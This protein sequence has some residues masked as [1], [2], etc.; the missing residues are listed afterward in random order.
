LH[1]ITIYLIKE[2]GQVKIELTKL[3]V[4]P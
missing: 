4:I 3:F 2:G 1:V